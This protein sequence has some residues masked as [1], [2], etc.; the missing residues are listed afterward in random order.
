MYGMS[1]GSMSET[2]FLELI[3]VDSLICSSEIKRMDL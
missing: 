3:Q 2:K 1:L